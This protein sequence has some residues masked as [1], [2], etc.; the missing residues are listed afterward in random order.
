MTLT[1][2]EHRILQGI[3]ECCRTGKYKKYS[4]DHKAYCS[5]HLP[6]MNERVMC[7]YCGDLIYVKKKA[8]GFENDMAFYECHRGRKNI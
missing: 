8:N 6:E 3:I 5:Y 7:D 1:D 2:L 4:L